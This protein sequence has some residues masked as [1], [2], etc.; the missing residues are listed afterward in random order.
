M[1]MKSAEIS[2]PWAA[3]GI[4]Q[5]IQA[6]RWWLLKVGFP[7]LRLDAILR[8]HDRPK[9]NFVSMPAIRVA[10]QSLVAAT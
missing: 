3:I 10:E 2:G 9:W 5:W 1:L 7:V 6:G 8:R 4:D